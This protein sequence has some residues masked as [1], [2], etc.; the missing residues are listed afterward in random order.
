MPSQIGR[1]AQGLLFDEARTPQRWLARDVSDEL[2]KQVLGLA[3]LA[4]TSGN[5]NHGRFVF[6]RTAE[7]KEALAEAASG[8]N[9]DKIRQAPVTAIIAY[10]SRFYERLPVLYPVGHVDQMVARHATNEAFTQ[11]VAFRNSALQGAY[12]IL[13]ARAF[14]LDCG[15]MSGFDNARVDEILLADTGWRSNFL[16]CLGYG[17]KEQLPPRYPRPSFEEVAQLR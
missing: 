8:R 10:D 1:D 11:E 13:A 9:P 17:D 14:G 16:C 15:P 12:L 3:L 7:G 4:P 6:V 5:G 2:L